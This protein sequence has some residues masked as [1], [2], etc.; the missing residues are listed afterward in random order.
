[1]SMFKELINPI[2]VLAE[3]GSID[4]LGVCH[5][6]IL[7]MGCFVVLN[8]VFDVI[9][10]VWMAASPR[11]RQKHDRIFYKKMEEMTEAQREG[12]K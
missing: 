10:D 8:F 5:L 6:L 3:G 12:S 2:R 11:R 9:D 7:L 1:M 4:L